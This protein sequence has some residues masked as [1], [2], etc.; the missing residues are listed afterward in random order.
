MK[1]IED[2][3][4]AKIYQETPEEMK[5]AI[6]C[7]EDRK[8]NMK[9]ICI[10]LMLGW[11]VGRFILLIQGEDEYCDICSPVG[12]N[13]IVW[14]AGLLWFGLFVVFLVAI[15][16]CTISCCAPLARTNEE[17]TII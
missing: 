1:E 9:V 4:I 2:Q 17:D 11:P 13:V 7:T 14:I 15:L 16:A 3:E 6:I 10:A 12:E 8:T 5:G